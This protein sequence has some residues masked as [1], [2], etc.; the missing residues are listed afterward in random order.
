MYLSDLYNAK[1][2]VF[3]VFVSFPQLYPPETKT[4]KIISVENAPQRLTGAW[5]SATRKAQKEVLPIDGYFC[6]LL[7]SL[8]PI[9]YPSPKAV[10]HKLMTAMSVSRTRIALVLLIP[11]WDARLPAW[12]F[13]LQG[14]AFGKTPVY[15]TATSVLRKIFSELYF[16][17][18]IIVSSYA[19][20]TAINIR[21]VY[22]LYK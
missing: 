12:I 16:L 22:P 21:L 8:L 17:N 5:E 2:V 10:R 19:I 6:G 7:L 3:T 18:C 1:N 14:D 11:I 4:H 13:R 9:A 15:G 20:W